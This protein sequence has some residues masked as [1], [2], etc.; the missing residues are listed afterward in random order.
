MEK[1]R[2]LER[3]AENTHYTFIDDTISE[4]SYWPCFQ[5]SRRE[6]VTP[7]LEQ[8][9]LAAPVQNMPNVGRNAPCPCGSNKK[10]KMCCGA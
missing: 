7:T 10:Y 2:V 9:R 8:F 6:P 3:L 1:E 4:M 5:Q